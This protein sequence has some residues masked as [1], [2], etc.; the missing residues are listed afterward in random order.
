MDVFEQELW[1]VAPLVITFYYKYLLYNIRVLYQFCYMGQ[2]KPYSEHVSFT[3]I[4]KKLNY[5]FFSY[6]AA[7]SLFG[8]FFLLFSTNKK[9]LL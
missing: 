7:K 5:L 2:L 8:D 9:Y 4:L 6:D 1:L 3:S